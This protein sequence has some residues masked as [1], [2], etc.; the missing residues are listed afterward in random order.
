MTNVLTKCLTWFRSKCRY[1]YIYNQHKIN[2]VIN[3]YSWSVIT[4][5]KRCQI[6]TTH[7]GTSTPH[8]LGFLSLAAKQSVGVL[9]SQKSAALARGS[10]EQIA[11]SFSSAMSWWQPWELN[12]FLLLVPPAWERPFGHGARCC[13]SPGCTLKIHKP[14]LSCLDPS[15]RPCQ[16]AISWDSL[17]RYRRI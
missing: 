16:A 14:E 1:T 4:L 10:Y 12:V 13:G 6:I 11:S 2:V 9:F 5:M 8:Q 7:N 17:L 3:I 15:K